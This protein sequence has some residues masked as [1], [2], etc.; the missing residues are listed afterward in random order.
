MDGLCRVTLRDE[1]RNFVTNPDRAGRHLANLGKSITAAVDASIDPEVLA[2]FLGKLPNGE[3]D[4]TLIASIIDLAS[5]GYEDF[6]TRQLPPLLDSLS[7]EKVGEHAIVGPMLR[8]NTRW[9]LTTLGRL[10]GRLLPT[11]F[12]TR[13][14]QR[15]FALP[16][17]ALVR[18]LVEDITRMI[19]WIETRIG[20]KAL[21][22]QFAGIRDRCGEAL[23]HQW[24]REVPPPRWLEVSMRLAA[25]RQRLPAYRQ[26][27]RLAARRQGY[28]NR[29][30]AARWQYIIELLAVDW[31]APISD[32][33]LFE[34]Y[35][36]VLVLDILERD[37]GLNR[38]TQYGLSVPGRDHIALF[39]SGTSRVRV[40]FDQSPAS[41]LAYPSY[42]LAI[43]AAHDGVRGVPRRPDLVV[44]HDGPPGRRVAFVEVKKTADGGYISDSVY[45]AL[46]Y[47]SDFRAIWEASPSKPNIVVLFPET[48]G[49]KVTTKIADQEVIL[50]SSF[51]RQTVA[52]ALRIGLGL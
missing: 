16:E 47:L 52:T 29:D 4:I 28:L 18:W 21:L 8:G 51:D 44:V 5:G 34:L 27:E 35:A 13:L 31:L 22:P 26:A 37:L 48:I 11:Q 19:S 12:V 43:L 36:L 46:G 17:N 6:C 45:K 1:W 2:D 32:D 15:S 7:N 24:F 42:Q 20:S 14:P 41:V 49:P 30:R 38:P 23:R 33:D 40:F 3:D 39:E 9:D 25:Q 50:A 10:S